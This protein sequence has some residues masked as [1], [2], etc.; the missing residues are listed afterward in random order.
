MKSY[1]LL[2]LP[3]TFLSRRIFIE[4]FVGA[5]P[6][7]LSE[8]NGISPLSSLR[9]Q[10]ELG[11]KIK[12][13]FPEFFPQPYTPYTHTIFSTN[14][15]LS[16]EG[17]Q[18][19]LLGE[20]LPTPQQLNSSTFRPFDQ[21]TSPV[22][23]AFT[24]SHPDLYYLPKTADSTPQPF[25]PAFYINRLPF[26]EEGEQSNSCPLVVPQLNL[27]L[28][29]EDLSRDKE[30]F[31]P[32][33]AL[34]HPKDPSKL[35]MPA[36][37]ERCLEEVYTTATTPQPLNSS[38]PL[39]EQCEIFLSY[40]FFLEA[41]HIK[42]KELEVA[43]IASLTLDFLQS[44]GPQNSALSFSLSTTAFAQIISNINP[45][46]IQCILDYYKELTSSPVNHSTLHPSNPST[47]QHL[48]SSTPQPLCLT[49][50]RASS[51]LIITGD[52]TEGPL[53]ILL[54]GSVVNQHIP[55]LATPSGLIN[56]FEEEA[57]VPLPIVCQSTHGD[58]PINRFLAFLYI[59]SLAVLINLARG[60]YDG[61]KNANDYEARYRDEMMFELIS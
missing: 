4:F 19:H 50:L 40:Y 12:E 13:R 10:Y 56:F 54:N 22:W 30:I 35:S 17:A 3:L 32:L 20:F 26:E 46:P 36:V 47:A 24:R 8:P 25:I 9:S 39:I 53:S 58:V 28:L 42:P 31:L 52:S 2:L 38:T 61:W 14:D 34:I 33:F 51:S 59:A 16:L 44:P 27:S 45:H 48:N 21:P 1:I 7:P 6:L 41:K 43:K 15:I 5:L 57:S 60:F 49:H 29:E 23:E 11:S 18:A 55:E 37:K